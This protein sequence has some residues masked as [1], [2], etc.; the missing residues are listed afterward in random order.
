MIKD[1]ELG[2]SGDPAPAEQ[3]PLKW[4]RMKGK[5]DSCPDIMD[6]FVIHSLDSNQN[7]L[8]NLL[9]LLLSSRRR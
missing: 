7:V 1:N 9:T 5:T 2:T 6:R 3:P 4:M 8:K